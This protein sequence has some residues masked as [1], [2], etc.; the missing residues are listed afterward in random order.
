MKLS[1]KILAGLGMVG[2]AALMSHPALTQAKASKR[3]VLLNFGADWCGECRL[4]TKILAEPEI[5]KFLDANFVTV[6]VE[7]GHQ[8]GINYTENNIETTRKYGAFTT[9]ASIAIPFMVVLDGNG[10]V[11]ARTN[12]SEWKHA[13]AITSETVLQA[14]KGWAPKS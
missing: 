12:N 9:A 13:P 1:T 4:M 2:V 14:L 6:K 7:V 11:L 10:T 8:V 3:Y 5:A